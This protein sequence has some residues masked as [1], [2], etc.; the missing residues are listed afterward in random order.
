MCKAH[1][2]LFINNVNV[3]EMQHRKNVKNLLDPGGS[4]FALGK[5]ANKAY[6]TVRR[7]FT[8]LIF[9]LQRRLQ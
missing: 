1:N 9:Y 5:C 7:T 4:I 2:I 3:T 6:R 8:E